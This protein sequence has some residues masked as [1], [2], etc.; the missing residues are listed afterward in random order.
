MPALDEGLAALRWIDLWLAPRWLWRRH[1]DGALARH[2]HDM[3]WEF[4][5]GHRAR[6]SA[7]AEI[8]QLLRLQWSSRM[9]I[10]KRTALRE[11]H[12][13]SRR[14]AS[15]DQRRK[16][17]ARRRDYV[18]GRPRGFRWTRCRSS[19]IFGRRRFLFG[20]RRRWAHVSSGADRT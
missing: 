2:R 18:S 11:R 14:G 13:R 10:H 15:G 7:S 5:V 20:Y 3:W 8:F 1:R 16:G 9:S 6:R 19:I 4:V 12:V 17:L